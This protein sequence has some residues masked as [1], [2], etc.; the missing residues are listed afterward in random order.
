MPKVQEALA[1]LNE[2]EQFHFMVKNVHRASD[3]QIAHMLSIPL[4]KVTTHYENAMKTLKKELAK[5]G[6]ELDLEV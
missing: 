3:K 2:G 5:L 1:N 6:V 4:K